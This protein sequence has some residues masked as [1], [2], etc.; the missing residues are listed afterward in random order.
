MD[1]LLYGYSQFS[2][3]K[4]TALVSL[5]FLF[6]RSNYNGVCAKEQICSPDA[7][8]FQLTPTMFNAQGG[9]RYVPCKIFYD[10]N[11]FVSSVQ[12]AEAK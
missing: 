9:F 7:I 4:G 1:I 10:M 2:S 11:G 5:S 12:L 8:K 3:K 6:E